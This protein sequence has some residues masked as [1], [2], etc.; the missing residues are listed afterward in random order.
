MLGARDHQDKAG[1]NGRRR[2]RQGSSL[3]V[4]LD[5][6]AV[7]LLYVLV[8]ATLGGENRWMLLLFRR[9][10]LVPLKAQKHPTETKECG[11][12]YSHDA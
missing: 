4:L 11:P 9:V 2:G 10:L 1:E 12:D 7:V 3:F 6:G 5:S 8:V